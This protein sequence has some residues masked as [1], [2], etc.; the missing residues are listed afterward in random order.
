[1]ASS[2]AINRVAYF[3]EG[4]S[5]SIGEQSIPVKNE[6][7]L[8]ASQSTEIMNTDTTKKAEI[9]ILQGKPLNEPVAQHGP[10][11]MNTREEIAQAFA[12]YQRTQFGG[13]PWPKDDMVF[14]KEKGRFALLNGK[15]TYPPSK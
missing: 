15:E 8:F 7:T 3:L 13:W 1:V 11:V 6:I 2:N 5:I 9:L 12:D 14:P 4:Q 10:F